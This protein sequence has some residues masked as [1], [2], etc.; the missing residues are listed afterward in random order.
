MNTY[1]IMSLHAKTMDS[2]VLTRSNAVEQARG[3]VATKMGL[4]DMVRSVFQDRGVEDDDGGRSP[5]FK[6]CFQLDPRGGAA[7][8]KN[9]AS[10]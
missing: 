9:L 3:W 1:A 6:Y 7:E 10:W 2:G 4:V 8:I 5:G